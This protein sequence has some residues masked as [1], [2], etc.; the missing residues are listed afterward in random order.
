MNIK[1]TLSDITVNF[2][3]DEWPQAQRLMEF[4]V[5]EVE[6]INREDFEVICGLRPPKPNWWERPTLTN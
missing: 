1:T 5:E 3:P 6:R 2:T 4:A